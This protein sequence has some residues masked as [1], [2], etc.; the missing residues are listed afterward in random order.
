MTATDIYLQ[1][2][3]KVIIPEDCD[4]RLFLV[5]HPDVLCEVN[6]KLI[7]E[8]SEVKKGDQILLT[9]KS[10]MK[11][12]EVIVDISEDRLSAYLQLKPA[13]QQKPAIE[14]EKI[15]D[16]LLIKVTTTVKKFFPFEIRQLKE[17]LTKHGVVY[18]INEQSIVELLA[19]QSESPL[20]VAKGSPPKPPV[21]ETVNILIDTESDSRPQILADGRVDYK[22]KRTIAV[23]QGQVLAVKIPGQPG[24]PGVGVDGNS[25]PVR[26]MKK[27]NLKAGPGAMLQQD[28]MSVVATERGCPLLSKSGNTYIF[29]VTPVIELDEINLST[30]NLEFN[31]DIRVAKDVTEG[32]SLLAGGNIDIGGSV[33]GAKI[34]SFGNVTISRNLISSSVVAGGVSKQLEQLEENLI[35]VNQAFKNMLQLLKVLKERCEQL[36]K[37]FSLGQMIVALINKNFSNIPVVVDKMNTLIRKRHFVVSTE[38]EDLLR[39]L[40]LKFKRLGWLKV[41]KIEEVE[42]LQSRTNAAIQSLQILSKEKNGDVRVSYAVNSTIEASGDVRV[43]GKGCINTNIIA[44]GDVIIDAVF[45]GG[46]INSSGRVKIKVAGS[47]MG[48]KTLIK[49][50]GKPVQIGKAFSNVR[51]SVG[52]NN[53]VIN[54]IEYDVLVKDEE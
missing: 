49:T 9:A 34:Y 8:T 14:L 45:R 23:E 27:I 5:P 10:E 46:A 47:E 52:S 6:G 36:N 21:D 19:T 48:A 50:S 13:L 51:I 42:K 15:Y 28:G 3:T 41:N 4:A 20:L 44:K 53:L 35:Y 38:I 18:G 22:K 12:A 31:G 1:D 54:N 2:D 29:R 37:E 40:E 17:Q 39:E 33:Y 43:D 16:D 25:I 32:M 30:G 7:V 26:E 11:P 24:Q